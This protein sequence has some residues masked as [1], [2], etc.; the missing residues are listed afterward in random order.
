MQCSSCNVCVKS[1]HRTEEEKKSLINR[2]SKIEGQTR[3]IKKM[4]EDD[5]FCDEILIQISAI[6]KSLKSLG[7]H[8]L[9]NHLNTCVVN[10][11]KENNLCVIDNVMNL[12]DRIK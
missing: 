2:L 12:F 8:I 7:N 11:I 6:N 9:K 10:N 4:I 5:R 3:G 1:K